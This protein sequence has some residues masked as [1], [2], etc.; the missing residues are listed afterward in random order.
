MITRRARIGRP[1]FVKVAE[2]V[3]GII[4]QVIRM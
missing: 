4:Q 1:E 2:S 3:L